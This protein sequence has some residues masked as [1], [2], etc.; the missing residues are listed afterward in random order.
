VP[1]VVAIAQAIYEKRA[2]ERMPELGNA[3]ETAG[4]TLSE[5]LSHCHSG[6]EHVRGCWVVDSILGRQ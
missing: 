2:F 4:C 1:P 5:V 6:H 3:L